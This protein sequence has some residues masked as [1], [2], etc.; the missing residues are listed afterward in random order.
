MLIVGLGNYGKEYEN[1]RHNVGFM[2]IDVLSEKLGIKICDKEC[3]SLVGKTYIGGK[4]VVL[5]KPQT[6]MNLSGLAVN[7]LAA[8]YGFSPS[9]IVVISDDID[10]DL[11][12]LRI[13]KSGSAGTH[14]GLKNIISE[15]SSKD[16]VRFRIGVGAKQNPDMDL[17]DYVLSRF[18]KK[19]IEELD[20]A[21]K[22]TVDGITE[23]LYGETIDIVMG[24]YNQK[25]LKAK[26]ESNE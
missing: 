16:F 19:E 25:K 18:S 7:A 15:L 26:T 14:N 10:L 1:T 21:F 6:Y 12:F 20:E 11:G 13:R 3:K 9:E 24:K 8:R 17:K 23:L 5:A 4:R 2:A 22:K